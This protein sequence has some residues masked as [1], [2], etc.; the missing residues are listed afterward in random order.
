MM[1]RGLCSS[2]ILFHVFFLLLCTP[3]DYHHG[4]LGI[5]IVD[6]QAFVYI[7]CCCLPLSTPQLAPH[8]IPAEE[9]SHQSLP[10]KPSG[11]GQAVRLDYRPHQPHGGMTRPQYG[12]MPR[13]QMVM[14]CAHNM[15]RCSII[16]TVVVRIHRTEIWRK[17]TVLPAPLNQATPTWSPTLTLSPEHPSKTQEV[18]HTLEVSWGTLRT[19]I[20]RI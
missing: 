6:P 16:L 20:W 7:Y 3:H 9:S 18:L 12:D 14:G 2:F 17:K 15:T 11:P 5:V 8:P 13:P 10:Q 1:L 4:Y 19:E